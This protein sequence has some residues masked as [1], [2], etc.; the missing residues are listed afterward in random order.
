[1]NLGLALE[2]R[3]GGIVMGG[4]RGRVDRVGTRNGYK[5]KGVAGLVCGVRDG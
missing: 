5:T 4:E 1:M 2:W 3:L